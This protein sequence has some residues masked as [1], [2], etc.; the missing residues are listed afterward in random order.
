VLGL[1]VE[2]LNKRLWVEADDVAND[3]FGFRAAA[4]AFARVFLFLVGI[5]DV[6]SSLVTADLLEV[7]DC[8]FESGEE[9][10]KFFKVFLGLLFCC[11]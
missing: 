2:V 5:G 1:F 11:W 9:N 6:G 8:F 10:K 4:A 3:G 7:G